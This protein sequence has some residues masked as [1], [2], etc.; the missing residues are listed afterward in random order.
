MIG[1]PS[2]LPRFRFVNPHRLDS[3]EISQTGCNDVYLL[4]EVG[5]ECRWKDVL[6]HE[7][8]FGTANLAH[9]MFSRDLPPNISTSNVTLHFQAIQLESTTHHDTRKYPTTN[10]LLFHIML[11]DLSTMSSTTT[12]TTT[13][14]KSDLSINST[15]TLPHSSIRIPQLGFGVYLSAPAVC[16][17]SCLEALKAGYRH[18]DTAQY[19]DN[20]A[21]VGKAIVESGIPREEIFVTT[22]ILFAKGSVEASL[23]GMRESVAKIDPGEGYVDLFLIHSPNFGAQKT[24]EMW[25]ALEM[26]KGEGK[27][28]AIGVSN[29]GVGQIEE[30]HGYAKE[31]VEV[32]QIEVRRFFSLIFHSLPSPPL[33]C[34]S[35]LLVF[36]FSKSPG[37]LDLSDMG[38]GDSYIPGA[39]NVKSSLTANKTTSSSKPI[40]PSCGTKKRVI[41]HLSLLRENMGKVLRRC[42]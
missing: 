37:L 36:S 26:L 10:Q 38:N 39:N 32:N 12:T 17:N 11:R 27:C 2:L 8:N 7:L 23:E 16:K 13:T 21:E 24:R 4:G 5:Q 18:I 1:V 34:T 19:Y 22:K 15:L 3:R 41:P 30:V 29:F 20:E 35:L 9:I 6:H 28:R 14:T 25:G 40:P 42:L 31:K 33:P